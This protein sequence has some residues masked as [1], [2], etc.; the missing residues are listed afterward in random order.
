VEKANPSAK[1][2]IAKSVNNMLL[3]L[4]DL[5][6]PDLKLWMDVYEFYFL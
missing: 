1:I 3:C 4:Q 2:K 6:V 5:L